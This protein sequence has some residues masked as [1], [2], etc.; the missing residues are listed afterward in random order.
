LSHSAPTVS[1][2]TGSARAAVF[3]LMGTL[4]GQPGSK[5]RFC[6]EL[7]SRV[8]RAPRNHLALVVLLCAGCVGLQARSNTPVTCARPGVVPR[9]LVFVA[10]GAGGFKAA[11][12]S[13]RETAVADGLP[14]RVETFDWTHGHFRVLADQVDR[15]HALKEG[16]ELA[17]E[18]AAAEQAC[19]GVQIS[20]VGHS[21]GCTVVLAAAES[22]PPGTLDRIVLLAPAVSTDHDLRPALACARRGIDV[23]YSKND[24]LYL[25]VGVAILGNADR[26]RSPAAGR[27]GFRPVL[28][29]PGDA[30][31]YANLRQ[32]PWEPSLEATGNLG[33]HYGA[34][35]PGFLRVAVLPL[36]LPDDN[37]AHGQ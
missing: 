7:R 28:A 4:L 20:L 32:Y 24:T 23:F 31:L 6:D 30:A 36:L 27:I 25:G 19:P 34:Y 22:L 17:R 26:E 35:Q 21:A 15:G 33:G 1:L 8:S 11:S 9:E 5:L 3:R 2:I 18:V 12:H 10:D 37:P 16:A 29:G 13:L 14:L